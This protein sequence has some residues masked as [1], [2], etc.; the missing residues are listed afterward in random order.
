L[1]GAV[2]A[3]VA[4]SKLCPEQYLASCV[5]AGSFSGRTAGLL[6]CRPEGSIE[7]ENHRTLAA[8]ACHAAFCRGV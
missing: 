6:G 4:S 2:I 8:R 1:I 5:P 3:A 7:N